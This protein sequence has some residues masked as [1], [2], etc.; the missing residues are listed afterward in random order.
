MEA[1]GG[2]GGGGVDDGWFGLVKN[3][4]PQTSGDI[5]F[6]TDIDNLTM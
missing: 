4:P 1:G 6:S 5:I 3:L 2:G